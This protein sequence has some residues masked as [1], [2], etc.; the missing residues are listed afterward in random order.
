MKLT[1][2]IAIIAALLI[3]W[4]LYGYFGSRVEQAEYSVIKKGNG[5]EIRNYP[6]HIIAQTTVSGSYAESMNQGFSIVAGYI[7]G[8]NIQKEKIAMTAPVVLKKETSEKIAMTAP[9]I[10]SNEGDSRTVSFGM[11]KSYTLQT[12][13]TPT[14]DRVKLV[15]V[16]EKKYAAMRFSGYRINNRIEDL[17]EKLIALLQADGVEVV[18]SPAYAGYNAPFTPP[19]MTRNEI[20]IEVK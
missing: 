9:V 5:Y 16:S 19:W 13:P 14:D 1:M 11:P 10:V 17:E 12:L 2:Y 6:A 15:E 4:S 7:F 20:L 3:V 8:G 18:G